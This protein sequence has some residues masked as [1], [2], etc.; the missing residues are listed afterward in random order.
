[1]K[2][3]NREPEVENA[4]EAF[5]E[6]V[7]NYFC[8]TAQESIFKAQFL[9][10]LKHEDAFQ[11][12]HLPGHITGS[13]FIV[14]EDQSQ[15]LLVHHVKLNKWL[16]PGG[17]T[18]GDTNVARVALREAN[19]ETGLEMLALSSAEI[20]DLDIHTIPA[21]KDFPQHDHF[22]VRY[23]FKASTTEKI[24]VS[25]ESHDVKWVSLS[26]LERYNNETSI[27]RMRNKLL[28]K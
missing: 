18:D 12:T 28:T 21:R 8:S 4:R 14:S 17:H 1:M 16:Q 22:D 10:L 20:F 11:R 25:E 7:K 19:E 2:S 6:T 24:I 5:L 15:T 23:L 26:E 27:L 9:D 3:E 13:A